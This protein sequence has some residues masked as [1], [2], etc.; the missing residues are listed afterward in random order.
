MKIIKELN[1]LR[2]N[3]YKNV[4][5][6]KFNY[7]TPNS[8]NNNGISYQTSNT[9]KGETVSGSNDNDDILKWLKTKC[10]LVQ[11]Y[12][13]F[14]DKGYNSLDVI[15]DIKSKEVLKD[16]GINLI[17]H[18]SKIWQEIQNLESTT[19]GQTSK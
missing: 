17:G 14:V 19:K 2:E 15:R 5:V 4:V 8:D 6:N 10:G 1:N 11:Y 13:L 12:D 7:I 16:I 3:E 18:R 9:S